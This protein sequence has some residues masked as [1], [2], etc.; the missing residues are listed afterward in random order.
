MNDEQESEV[1]NDMLK[2]TQAL[3]PMVQRIRHLPTTAARVAGLNRLRA[4]AVDARDT[5]EGILDDDTLMQPVISD[6]TGIIPNGDQTMN[7]KVDNKRLPYLQEIQRIASQ[8][9]TIA[10]IDDFFTREIMPE[11]FPADRAKKTRTYLGDQSFL[12]IDLNDAMRRCN[13][14]TLNLLKN[15]AHAIELMEAM[16]QKVKRQAALH[17]YRSE[18]A[19]HVHETAKERIRRV[20]F[21]TVAELCG[22]PVKAVERVYDGLNWKAFRKQRLAAV[23]E[24]VPGMD[25]LIQ[26]R[27][28][29]AIVR[30]INDQGTVLE[31]DDPT[32]GG[33]VMT[34]AEEIAAARARR[35]QENICRQAYLFFEALRSELASHDMIRAEALKQAEIARQKIE[36]LQRIANAA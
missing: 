20:A 33:R 30:L 35:I 6:D 14:L 3:L 1:Y 36:R 13:V 21:E 2:F 5:L 27:K 26:R 29:A 10:E 18:Q 22:K 11:Q 16:F 19:K 25:E 7:E 8:P 15:D 24:L 4:S 31:E 12:S 23:W 9:R 34:P 32:R 28:P 17:Q